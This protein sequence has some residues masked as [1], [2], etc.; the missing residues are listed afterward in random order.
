MFYL[1]NDVMIVSHAYVVLAAAIDQ[2]AE[3]AASLQSYFITHTQC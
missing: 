2:S 3:V 1:C